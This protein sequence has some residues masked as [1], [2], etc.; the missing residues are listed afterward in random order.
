MA[1]YTID[2]N[3][4]TSLG[5]IKFSNQLV[6]SFQ[7]NL[8]PSSIHEYIILKLLYQGGQ[9]RIW[10]AIKSKNPGVCYVIKQYDF[11][12]YSE[13]EQNEKQ[14]LNSL[15]IH[16]E[17]FKYELVILNIAKQANIP[18][19]IYPVE[20]F[21]DAATQYGYTVLPFID[22]PSSVDLF[23]HQLS[24]NDLLIRMYQLT[25]CV[26]SLHKV[27]IIHGDIKPR[28][29]LWDRVSHQ[30]YMTDFG[31]AQIYFPN[32]EMDRHVGTI[33]FRS[34]EL[35]WTQFYPLQVPL[36]LRNLRNGYSK[37]QINNGREEVYYFGSSLHRSSDIWSLGVTFL[38]WICPELQNYNRESRDK[39][40]KQVWK[41][42]LVN[43]NFKFKRLKNENMCYPTT[44]KMI[45]SEWIIKNF[46]NCKALSYR[47][48]LLKS[49]DQL[50]KHILD[51]RPSKRWDAKQI[52]EFL[53]K[54]LNK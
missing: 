18:Y 19:M 54:R 23:L 16:L 20:A 42:S 5:I 53:S 7:I 15:F 40:F 29:V 34:P 45:W 35:T 36:L 22:I 12:S 25:Q 31:S 28:N 48:D 44:C 2:N 14:S 9:G 41:Q 10:I 11:S 51:T 37:F 52:L 8:K 21:Y 50:F 26:F 27:G 24:N 43:S 47:S 49:L 17:Q 4:S 1:E 39:N 33:A 38:V 3:S 30:C 32:M 46:K 6:D 13:R